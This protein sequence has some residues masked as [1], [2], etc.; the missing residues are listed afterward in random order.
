M[1]LVTGAT[2]LSGFLIMNEF[3]RQ[4]VPVRALV[5]DRAKAR[6]FEAF[7]TVEIVEGD[8]QRPE[9]LGRA[10]EGV[11]RV[12]MI[13][14]SNAQM[15]ETQCRFIDT[16]KSAGVRH[17]VK[18]SGKESGVGFNQ[19]YFRF[20]RFHE[21]IER[22]LEGSGLAWTH[23]RPSQFMQIYLRET[24]T[25][26]TQDTFFL[27]MEQIRIS[28]IDIED[29]AKV[30]VALLRNGG[31]EGKAYDMTGPEA[32]TMTEVAECISQVVG[33][34]IR[35]QNISLTERRQMLLDRGIPTYSIDA[36]DEQASE[37]L[38]CPESRICL[39]AHEAFGVHPTTFAQFAHRHANAF[40]GV[41][42]PNRAFTV[43]GKH[44]K[45]E[46]II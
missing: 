18:F 28:P 36:L 14:S 19:R 16:A 39:E 9:T 44:G 17:L 33:R 42:N 23:L 15:V 30:A 20:T 13:S 22:Y 11:E 10:L 12:L 38:R 26:A 25:I 31:H 43:S 32:L 27:P 8:M 40:L 46:Q 7:P 41:P 3:T 4:H 45:D 24:P 21:E 35:Y 6:M 37:R 2:G 5:R 29:I 34:R 1:I